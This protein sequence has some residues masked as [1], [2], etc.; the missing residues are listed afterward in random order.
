M[1]AGQAAAACSR[2]KMKLMV[3]AEATHLQ[4][5]EK[6]RPELALSG[7]LVAGWPEVQYRAR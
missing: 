1:S 7:P 6:K 3:V 2:S 5:A 4:L